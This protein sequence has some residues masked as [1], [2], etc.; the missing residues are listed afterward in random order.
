MTQHTEITKMSGA[1]CLHEARKDF[2]NDWGAHTR[3]PLYAGHS[4]L[5]FKSGK[6]HQTE[7]IY[8]TNLHQG[9]QRLRLLARFTRAQ[10]SPYIS[11]TGKPVNYNDAFSPRLRTHQ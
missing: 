11:G 8:S 10:T 3:S 7:T 2:N 9:V 1:T 4:F 5:R 6:T